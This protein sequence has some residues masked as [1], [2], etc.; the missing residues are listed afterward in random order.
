MQTP[1]FQPELPSSQTVPGNP[2]RL[3]QKI[4]DIAAALGG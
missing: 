1:S 2:Q 3:V 4:N